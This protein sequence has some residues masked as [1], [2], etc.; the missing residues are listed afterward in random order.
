M[1]SDV[2]DAQQQPGWDQ[3]S[4]EDGPDGLQPAAQH[5]DSN[6]QNQQL[7][8]TSVAHGDSEDAAEYD[9]DSIPIAITSPKAKPLK[10]SPQPG[11]AKKRKTAGGFLV[12]DSDDSEDENP[13]TASAQM[14]DLKPKPE[15]SPVPQ[16]LNGGAQ[17]SESSSGPGAQSHGSN[18]SHPSVVPSVL[19]HDPIALLELRVKEDPRG[20]M[21]SWLSLIAAYRQRNNIEQCRDVFERFLAVFP[22]SAEI[23][24]QYA[25]MELSQGNFV[26]AEAIFGKS[27]MSVPNVQLWTVYLDY[28]R[29]RNDLNDSSG[30]ARQVVT[31]AYDFVIDNVGLDKDA[32]KIWSDYIQFIRLAPGVVGGSAWQDQQKMDQL[33]KAYQRAVCIPLSN[34]NT[35]WR[36]Y[37]QFEKGLN[38]TTGRKYL[39]ERSPAYM[40]A[41]SANTALE[42]ITRNL[43][44]TTLPRLP[45]APG[46]EGDVEFAE[47]VDLWKRWI[48]W[49]KEDPL[50]LATD[51]PELLKKRILYAYKQAIMA[52]R[53]WPE[54]WVDAAEW[55][56]ENSIS[57]NGKD[58]GLEFLTEGIEANPESVLLALKHA[59]RIETTFPVGEGDEAKIERGN[60]VKAPYNKL[61]DTLYGQIKTLKEKEKAEILKLRESA[62]SVPGQ[63]IEEGEDC[64]NPVPSELEEKISALEKGFGAQTDLLARTVSFVWIALAR[65]MRRIQGKGQPGSPMGGMR[66]VFS[67]AR[68]RGRLT[69][70]VYVAIAQLEWTVYKDP[71]GGKIFDRGS[72]LFPEDEIFMLE[73]LKYLHSREDTTN[74]RVVFETCVNKLTQ[75]PATVHKAKPLYSYFHKYES[76]FGELS[77]TAK[78]EKRMAELFPE[79]PFLAHFSAR[80]M[81][82]RF[83]PIA[84]RIIVSPA[85]QLRPKMVMPSIETTV[86]AG[87]PMIRPLNSPKA[88]FLQ[89]VNSPKR[90]LPADDF[91]DLNPPKKIQRNDQREF[92]RAESPLKGAAGRRLENQRRIHGQ[93]PASY[94]AAP[95]QAIPREINFLL[96]QLPGAEVYNSTR[97]SAPRV[98]DMLR[99][100]HV[101]D[102]Q[103]W[104]SRQDKGLRQ[105]G[106][107][108]PSDFSAPGYGRDSPGL[109]TGSPFGCDRRIASASSTYQRPASRDSYEP[110]PPSGYQPP[111]ASLQYP[112]AT[113]SYDNQPTHGAWPPPSHQLPYGAPPPAQNYAQ[114]PPQ[115]Y[116]T[117][118]GQ[119]QAQPPYGTYRY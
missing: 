14:S 41:K 70:D 10:P 36:E 53:F 114:P 92:Q 24:V 115:L 11:A 20:A 62:P 95:A 61:L 79:D 87:S 16:N 102:Y 104:K 83:D 39:N 21:D 26:E 91:E 15:S 100:T 81:S 33:R 49:E 117:S 17:V 2:G 23:W 93:G 28:I 63:E 19:S 113:P 64:A 22:H 77:Q 68:K 108:M 69:S 98:V 47:Q 8:A 37:D 30:R 85:A 4:T 32:S 105:S 48:K 51:D 1:A 31:Q 6:V 65:A 99:D 71:S 59:D 35:L 18:Q 56:F 94:N 13:P 89:A 54:I 116:Q 86:R 46:F 43:V 78:L 27:L 80:F 75:N 67:E 101:P 45:P 34:V 96:S 72:K 25:D 66:Q 88:G 50:D 109:R 5:S 103:S 84:A 38:P 9:P 112:P 97:L 58:A 40:T 119:Q 73:Y 7:Q 29:R 3:D 44:R 76:K 12:G 74:A 106:A 42:N 90:P 82:D 118:T 55:C 57:V 60:A 110:P 52:L 107:Q 111:A